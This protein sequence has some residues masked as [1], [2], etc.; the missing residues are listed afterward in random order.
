MMPSAVPMAPATITAVKPTTIDTRA[1]KMRRDSTSRPRWS[2]PRRCSALPPVCQAGGWKRAASE[3]ISGSK[4]ATK[5]A[6]VAVKAMPARISTGT[7]GNPLS[8]RMSSVREVR[9][10]ATSE[11][12]A[13]ASALQPDAWIDHRVKDVDQQVHHHDHRSAE[14]NDGLDHGKVA[15]GDA[16]VEQP[17][18]AGPGEHRLHDDGNVDHDDKIDARQGQHGDKSVLE[19]V[20][21]DDEGLRESLEASELDVFRPQHL[22]H[23]GAR[24]PHVSGGEIP[25]E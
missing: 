5:L 1:P 16:L 22:Q 13:M 4:G 19:G 17:A 25:P 20:L 21:G 14:Q 9:G 11:R 15:E 12:I 6:N 2:V 7:S 23:G 3:P 18:D 8:P 24:E 10:T